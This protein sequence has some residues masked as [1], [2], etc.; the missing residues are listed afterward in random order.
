MATIRFGMCRLEPNCFMA[1]QTKVNHETMDQTKPWNHGPKPKQTIWFSNCR[2]HALKPCKLNYQA[3][4]EIWTKLL[5]PNQEATSI[6]AQTK[7]LIQ[8]RSTQNPTATMRD[9]SICSLISH[10]TNGWS[11]VAKG[12]LRLLTREACHTNKDSMHNGSFVLRNPKPSLEGKDLQ[13]LTLYKK[14]PL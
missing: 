4:L 9:K 3:N 2:S 11:L 5:E 12:L 14:V 6:S 7:M 8:S 10:A 1:N 13:G